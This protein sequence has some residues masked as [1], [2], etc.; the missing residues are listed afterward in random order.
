MNLNQKKKKCWTPPIN[1]VK[2]CSGVPHSDGRPK[3]NTLRYNNL[4]FLVFCSSLSKVILLTA[5]LP[6]LC[7][8]YSSIYQVF[9]LSHWA[10]SAF[11]F[12][13]QYCTNSSEKRRSN[14]PEFSCL[15]IV[16]NMSSQLEK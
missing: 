13:L 12:Y 16:Q 5:E 3:T 6:V 11:I 1:K 7:N 9:C 15:L 4:V 10:M 2:P 14:S 8:V